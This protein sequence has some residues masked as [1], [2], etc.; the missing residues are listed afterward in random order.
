[1]TTSRTHT[2]VILLILGTWGCT[3]AAEV[4]TA[5]RRQ[6]A[7]QNKRDTVAALRAFPASASPD[8]V[9]GAC[10]AVAAV[11]EVPP[12]LKS[13][14]GEAFGEQ[15]KD[16]FRSGNHKAAISAATQAQKFGNTSPEVDG[17][18]REANLQ[19]ALFA[20][21]QNPGDATDKLS[22]D[23]SAALKAIEIAEGVCAGGSSLAIPEKT[24]DSMKKRL[25]PVAKRV[26]KAAE[27]E[28]RQVGAVTRQ[29]YAQV[30]QNKFYDDGLNIK[31]RTSGPDT[32][33]LTMTFVLFDE[34]W[35]H[36]FQKGDLLDEVGRQGFKKVVVNDGYTKSWSW[37]F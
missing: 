14:C 5:R 2:A 33:V 25:A 8:K 3:D 30:L 11:Q 36:N 32:T 37:K 13:R 18:L 4:E 6:A 22:S 20:F 23:P 35:V 24:L 28:Q 21:E 29:A 9:V 16:L 17:A 12:D 7:E 27:T 26:R 19:V 31:V 34:V 10:N 1:M 15:A